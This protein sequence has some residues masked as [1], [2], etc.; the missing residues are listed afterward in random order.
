MNEKHAYA[1]APA[2]CILL[3]RKTPASRPMVFMVDVAAISLERRAA[4]NGVG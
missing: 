2:K 1:G 3:Y 4:I